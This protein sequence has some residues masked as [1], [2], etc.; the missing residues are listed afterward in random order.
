MFAKRVWEDN[1]DKF[2][3]CQLD[4][5]TR[6]FILNSEKSELYVRKKNWSCL[7]KE[8]KK[9]PICLILE[10]LGIACYKLVN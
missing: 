4:F 1:K 7:Y 5:Y 8:R 6:K 9:E 2:C 3:V 10:G